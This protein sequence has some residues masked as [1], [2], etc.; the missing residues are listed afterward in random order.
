MNFIIRIKSLALFYCV[1]YR[2]RVVIFVFCC[3]SSGC[4]IP[5]TWGADSKKYTT[6]VDFGFQF[7]CFGFLNSPLE[8]LNFL[9]IKFCQRMGSW[10]TLNVNHFFTLLVKQNQSTLHHTFYFK[11][12]AW[13]E[14]SLRLVK[15]TNIIV[16]GK[17]WLPQVNNVL[18][19]ALTTPHCSDT[20]F[21]LT[22]WNT[23]RWCLHSFIFRSRMCRE[24][25]MIIFPKLIE[26]DS[27]EASAPTRTHTIH[28][29]MKWL[30][31]T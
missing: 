28:R 7:P 9:C 1:V 21:N 14:R 25:P 5:C 10:R 11:R 16:V 8:V 12:D 27:S 18:A 26:I 22:Y 31:E 20:I 4:R 15:L 6:P 13:R 24:I 29:K 23:M 2:W 30:Y 17:W 19:W 3:A